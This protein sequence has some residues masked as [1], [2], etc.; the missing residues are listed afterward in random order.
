LSLSFIV[1]VA[2]VCAEGRGETVGTSS[3]P[4]Q[5]PWMWGILIIGVCAAV[6]I[7]VSG[8]WRSSRFVATRWPLSVGESLLLFV[9]LQVLGALGAEIGTRV[10]PPQTEGAAP[11]IN[12]TLWMIG[13]AAVLQIIALLLFL[14]RR[15]TAAHPWT[16]SK[17]ALLGA[18]A[19][20]AAWFPLQAIGIAVASVQVALGGPA[21]PRE[22]HATLQL[23]GKMPLDLQQWFLIGGV[24]VVVP[25][26]E[27]VMF[28]GALLGALRRVGL[29]VWTAIALSAAIFALL[30]IPALVADAVAPGLAMLFALGTLL[31]WCAARTGSLA[32]PIMAHALFNA[33][34]VLQSLQSLR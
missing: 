23:L 8:V 15:D 19:L 27:E 9:I 10:A 22:G 2:C 28:R 25:A 13:S 33:A 7:F 6:A 34:N 18:A 21:V 4:P 16:R 29:P 5:S 24:V 26:I 12:G 14:M 17:S 11:S 30:H 1:A 32:A 3:D 31:G 20:A